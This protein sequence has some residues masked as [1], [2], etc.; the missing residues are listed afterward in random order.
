MPIIGPNIPSNGGTANG[1]ATLDN[2]GKLTSSQIP[3]SLAFKA[4]TISAGSGLT[5]GGDLSADRTISMP[6]VGIPGVYGAADQ[7]SVLTLDIQGRVSGIT[8]SDILISES[9]V[10]GL[11][12]DLSSISNSL[13]DLALGITG[14]SDNKADKSIVI[15]SV[16]GLTGGGDLSANR[17]FQPVYG[18]AAN[19]V[20]EGND[21]RLSDSRPPTG[22]AGGDLSDSSYPNPVLFSWQLNPIALETPVPGTVPTWNGTA[23]V[24]TTPS[25]GGSGGGGKIYYFNDYVPGTAPTTGLFGST[26]LLSSSF[27]SSSTSFTSSVLPTGGVYATVAAFVTDPS[28]PN[29]ISLPSGLWDFNIWASSP[30][31]LADSV[32]FRFKLYKYDGLTPTLISTSEPVFLY[33]PT[34]VKQ[35]FNLIAVPNTPLLTTDRIYIEVEASSTIASQTITLSFGDNTAGSVATTV[36]SISG[37]GLVHVIDGV[38]QS[39]ATPVNLTAGADVTGILPVGYGGLGI[40]TIPSN[41]FIPIGD[42]VNYTSA[43]IS[44]G[45]GISIINGPGSITVEN[46]G[47]LSL[48]GLTGTLSGFVTDA[49][50][51]LAGPGLIGGGFLSSDVT[52]S[53]PSFGFTGVFGSTSSTSVITTD[54]F[55]RVIGAVDTPILITIDQVTGLDSSL[56]DKADKTTSIFAGTGLSGGGDLSADRTISMPYV[57]TAG[58]YGSASSVPVFTT[59]DQGRVTSVAPISVD[60][61]QSQVIGLV[62][63]L[64][65]KVPDSRQVIA[66]T[67]LTGGGVLTAD[68]TISLQNVG[69]ATT[70]GTASRSATITTDAQGRVTSLT[71]QD[72]SISGSQIT[73]GVVSVAQGGTNLTSAGGVANRAVY[74][75]DGTT[76]TVGQLPNAALANSS[77]TLNPGT[78]LTGGGAVSLGGS[79]SLNLANTGV[80]AASYGSASSVA[81]FTTN[82]QGQ[83]TTAAS[84]PIAISGSQITSGLISVGLGTVIFSGAAVQSITAASNTINPTSSYHRLNNTTGGNITLTSAPTISW[85]TPTL[86][87]VLVLQSIVGMSNNIVIQRGSANKLSLN[88][89]TRTL[90]AGATIIFI[91]DGNLWVEIAFVNGTSAP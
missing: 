74:T 51:V 77:I 55:G 29:S 19:T 13:N 34:V 86:G 54:E 9:Q 26:K 65:G 56:N 44:T 37:T 45:P 8:A 24:P 17:T 16:N 12:S 90:S 23:W 41:G 46:I 2:D 64:S 67:G 84:T 6:D 15:N 18:S 7:I 40:S 35:Y 79:T 43:Q 49:R 75:A 53:L 30:S 11:N 82:A 58:S 88:G 50:S 27:Q 78:G 61:S 72:I 91:W 71:D 5:G 48:N 83:L 4:T 59:D 3:D 63:D 85:G 36:P 70:K 73:S 69:T 66:G 20:T 1:T 47:V 38:L 62:S 89:A 31:S 68:V 39:P 25:S 28:D 32:F 33:V 60:I 21:P 42:G 80:V 52:I 57:G 10:S 76:F 14:L 81:T 22:L 87:Q